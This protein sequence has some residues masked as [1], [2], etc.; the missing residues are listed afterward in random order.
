M[1]DTNTKKH[2]GTLQKTKTTEGYDL[3][4]EPSSNANLV[5]MCDANL[6]ITQ[7]TRKDTN[8]QKAK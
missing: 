6:V 2:K 1:N 8:S 3:V 7:P 4:L 5:I